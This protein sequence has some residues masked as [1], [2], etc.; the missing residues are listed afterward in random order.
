[1]SKFMMNIPNTSPFNCNGA[2]LSQPILH[3]QPPNPFFHTYIP[4][5]PVLKS[6]RPLFLSQR[7]TNSESK[8]QGPIFR[9]LCR[10]FQHQID[11]RAIRANIPNKSPF[12]YNETLPYQRNLH[13]QPPLYP[14]SPPLNPI[15]HIHF[16]PLHSSPES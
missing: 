16:T 5:P 14:L 7:T 8:T 2:L 11:V 3:P 1:M 4:F 6:H 9:P 15:Q 13:R 12:N 10:T